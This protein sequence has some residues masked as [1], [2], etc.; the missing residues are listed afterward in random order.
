ME[1]KVIEKDE[2]REILH[3]RFTNL[4]RQRENLTRE[5]NQVCALLSLA[6]DGHYWDMS[7]NCQYTAQ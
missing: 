3:Q 2:E 7:V 4:L 1:K 5:L 6:I